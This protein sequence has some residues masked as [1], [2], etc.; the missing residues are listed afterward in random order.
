MSKQARGPEW[1]RETAQYKEVSEQVL[2]AQEAS[3][4]ATAV[5]D[6]AS[7]AAA[8]ELLSKVSKVVKLGDKRRLDT[9]EPYRKSTEAINAEFKE[10]TAPLAGVEERLREE[11]EVFEAKRRADEAEARRKYEEELKR[12]ED[13][14]IA[15]EAEQKKREEEA[16]AAAAKAKADAEAAE[17]PPPPEPPPLPPA[18]LP[19]P[20]PPP[21]PPPRD[22]TVRKTSTGSVG[23]RTE[24]KYEVIDFALVPDNLKTL[25]QAEATRLVR[26]GERNISGMRI[27]PVQKATVR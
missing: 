2:K 11:V 26:G 7:C 6:D 27:Y 17:Q 24:W 8:A 21:P 18:P 4:A 1:V 9:S 22:S 10:L 16:A 23:T 20:P 25:N 19:P 14:R 12:A 3:R 13:A 15:A 5:T